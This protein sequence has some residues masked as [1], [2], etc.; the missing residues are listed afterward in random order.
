MVDGRFKVT[1]HE[2]DTTSVEVSAD[3]NLLR[4]IE[5]YV[6]DSTLHIQLKKGVRVVMGNMLVNI[7]SPV[8]H[9][10]TWSTIN[11][12]GTISN[13]AEKF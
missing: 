7:K 11:T 13:S 4:V 2:S 3:D 9:A 1:F 8:Y 6:I 10:I 12:D 5:I